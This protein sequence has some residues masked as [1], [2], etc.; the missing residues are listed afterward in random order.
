MKP[1]TKI[2][3]AAIFAL[4][5]VTG[6]GAWS[7]ETKKV[8][9]KAEEGYSKALILQEKFEAECIAKSYKRPCIYNISYSTGP[10]WSAKVLPVLPGIAIIN[11]A[12]Y[13]G[14]KWA[15]G[16]TRIEFWYGFGSITLY[17]FGTWVS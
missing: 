3:L 14:P 15:E 11:S 8:S 2:A 9:Q 6:V 7:Q 10:N 13:V 1:R 4:Y 17:D 16:S 12:Y 5:G